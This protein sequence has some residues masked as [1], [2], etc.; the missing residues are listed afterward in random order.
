MSGINWKEVDRQ[1]D[2]AL[3]VAA[4]QERLNLS[5]KDFE[6]PPSVQS[7]KNIRAINAMR[8]ATRLF[9]ALQAENERLTEILDRRQ[10]EYSASITRAE[11]EITDTVNRAEA[12][13]AKIADL[14]LIENIA[15]EWVAAVELDSSWD[16]WDHHYKAMWKLLFRLKQEDQG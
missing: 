6:F 15:R 11:R 16:G 12:A 7:Q 5:A 8:D 2:A 3:D 13:E 9:A 14:R 10:K 4:L 1:T